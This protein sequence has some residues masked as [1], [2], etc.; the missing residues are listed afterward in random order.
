MTEMKGE[1]TGMKTSI[2]KLS[3]TTAETVKKV[4][5]LEKSV[6]FAHTATTTNK[7]KLDEHETRLKEVEKQLGALATQ[8]RTLETQ[9]LNLERHSREFNV[10]INGTKPKEDE[11]CRLVVANIIVDNGW[12]DLPVGEVGNMLENAHRTGKPKDSGERQLI[13]RFYCRPDRNAILRA[14]RKKWTAGGPK[15]FP[16]MVKQ[17][18]D[19]KKKA[20][21]FMTKAFEQ[22]HKVQFRNG[23]MFINGKKHRIP[24][25]ENIDS[26][27]QK[28]NVN[29]R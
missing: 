15:I 17:D 11:D 16:D 9:I 27:L 10:R 6:E 13:A 3:A 14:A 8:N 18:F 29:N 22:G 1:L 26:E 24:E 23:G 25:E 4:T 21:P 7:T 28:L 5:E 19:L 2:E 12:S 20:A